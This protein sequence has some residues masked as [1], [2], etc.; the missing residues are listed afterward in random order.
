[1]QTYEIL[2]QNRAVKG[3]SKD[4]T[5]VRTS[6]GIDQVH[7][8]F[9]SAEWLDFPITITFAQG[10]ELVTQSLLV[11]TLDGADW[12]A[13]ATVTV[14]YEVI[15][16]TGPIR[17][18]L[19]GT[20]G[21]GRHI[22]TAKG[23]PLSVEEAGDVIVG[24][25]PIDAPPTDQW[26]QAYAQAMA[27]ANAAQSVANTLESR[28]EEIIADAEERLTPSASN[29]PVATKTTI[30]GVIVGSNLE[31]DANGRI[32]VADIGKGMT[33]AQDATLV[34][35]SNL[36]HI[37]FD[38]QFDATGTLKSNARLKSTALPIA[39]AETVGA[40][41]VDGET[42]TIG[43]DGTIG[44]T[45]YVLPAASEVVLGGIKVGAGLSAEEDG[46][47]TPTV[48][49]AL[50]YGVVRPDGVTISIDDGILTAT[51]GGG[52]GSYTLPKASSGQLGGV[53][54]GAGLSIDGNGVLS[55]DIAVADEMEF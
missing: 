21:E 52:S 10:D 13:E 50:E 51:G 9:D 14:P 28:I 7:I 48:A 20:D 39:T 42:V 24:E 45:P 41:K 55:V 46:T 19:Q 27:A 44:V 26:Q 2:V 54:V 11:T 38:T 8:L 16:M 15:D 36:V 3:N 1:M 35:L 18:T 25:P 5:L 30:G 6:V 22:I 40:V 31:V 17:V 4:M 29:L 32:Y 12:V 33:S 47:L 49:T 43:S 53:K 34:N 37:C 23:S